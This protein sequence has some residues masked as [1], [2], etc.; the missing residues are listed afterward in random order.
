MKEVLES[1]FP[2]NKIPLLVSLSNHLHLHGYATQVEF[3]FWDMKAYKDSELPDISIVTV[4]N[5]VSSSTLEAVSKDFS[6]YKIILVE[7][8][9]ISLPKLVNQSRFL[10][11][12]GVGVYIRN[13]GWVVLPG[14]PMLLVSEDFQLLVLEK[15]TK[16]K[17]GKWGKYCTKCGAWTQYNGFYKNPNSNAR[18][19][20]RNHCKECHDGR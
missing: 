2:D 4:K 18:D 11:M 16:N 19:P 6:P 20:R 8:D 15:Y 3:D 10:A 5:H 7:G 14:K 1:F 17:R 12:L 9:R 13:A